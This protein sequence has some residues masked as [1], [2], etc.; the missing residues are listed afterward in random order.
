M[1]TAA[2]F[3]VT[4]YGVMDLVADLV[5]AENLVLDEPVVELER[6]GTHEQSAEPA[7]PEQGAPA[8][9]VGEQEQAR[10]D[11]E[12]AERVEHTVGNQAELEGGLVVEVVPMKQLVEYGLVNEGD[13]PD[14]RQYP[15]QHD[16]TGGSS[17][18]RRREE[19]NQATGPP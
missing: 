3:H 1:I 5:Q 15:R 8:T 4:S 11:G 12:E 2:A 17:R 6:P 10:D 14:P 9:D 13:K 16:P 19:P 7:G 18:L